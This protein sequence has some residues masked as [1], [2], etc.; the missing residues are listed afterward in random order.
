MLSELFLAPFFAL[1]AAG[2]VQCVH[3]RQ[4]NKRPAKI[5]K[6]N[7]FNVDP[8]GINFYCATGLIKSGLDGKRAR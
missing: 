5:V 4:L 2:R 6:T 3:M 1:S 7:L 8:T